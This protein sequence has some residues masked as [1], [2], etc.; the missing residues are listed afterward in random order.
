M[1]KLLI[2]ARLALRNVLAYRRRSLQT[3]LIVA[4]GVF[5]VVLT[6]SFM[7][8]FYANLMDQVLAST[9]HLSITAPGYATQREVA[10]IDLFVP[11]IDELKSQITR[12]DASLAAAASI[13]CAG[14][15][16]DGERS[17]TVSCRGIDPFWKGSI[18]PPLRDVAGRL[19]G[20]FFSPG[21]GAGMLVS[22]RVAEKLSAVPGD[23]LM[24]LCTDRYGSFG[25][26]EL[27]LRG[28]F[29]KGATLGEEECLIDLGSMQTATGLEGAAS[30]VSVWR[31]VERPGGRVL[32]DP[33]ESSTVLEETVRIARARGAVVQKW[34]EIS[35]SYG[36]MATFLDLFVDIVYA[37][38]A[39]V[40]AMG[41][42]NSVLLSVQDRIRDVGTLRVVALSRTGVSAMIALESL[43][44]GLCGG[45][46]GALAG[47]AATWL[48]E[49]F[50]FTLSVQM[51]GIASYLG[52]GIAPRF[53]PGRS[54][55]IGAFAAIVPLLASFLPI[56]SLRRITIREALGYV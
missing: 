13:L 41:M 54:V 48:L 35:A 4:L 21:G 3:F 36:S 56:L 32:A 38:F 52:N 15:V 20:R 1:S 40:A 49:R 29:P 25:V 33:A 12:Q 39:I 19:E 24:F 47:G 44:L 27:P 34:S 16:S 23:K 11:D 9:G 51:E 45:A 43:L 55:L 53:F 18:I 50:G 5:L 42:T 30:E 46:T 2:P 8:G 14:L 6:D 31:F 26:V 37:I 10:P 22:R 17:V 28:V 7:R